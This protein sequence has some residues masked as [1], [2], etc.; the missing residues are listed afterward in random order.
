[1]KMAPGMKTASH[2]SLALFLLAVIAGC[3]GKTT[4]TNSTTS[5]LE[6]S[7]WKLVE[8]NGKTI[9]TPERQREAHIILRGGEPPA[10]GGS[11]GCN[12]LMGSYTISGNTI[13][14][15]N[16]AMTMMACPQG[17]ETEYEF[18]EVLRGKKQWLITGDTLLLKNETGKTVAQFTVQYM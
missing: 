14:F 15:G 11:G 3:T 4:Q 18:T 13:T 7:Y 9:V 16:T 8:L 10:L 1:M 17:M 2:L 6:N 5:S 12:R